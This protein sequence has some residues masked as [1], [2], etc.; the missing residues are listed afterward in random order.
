MEELNGVLD[1][2]QESALGYELPNPGLRNF[3]R[4]EIERVY[5]VDDEINANLLELVKMIMRCNKEDKDIP[6]EERK[7]IRVF[8][9]SPGGDITALWSTIK[10]IEISKT[11]VWT[12]NYCGCHSAAADLLA[13]GHK[14]F[15]LPGTT[16]MVHNGSC[17][18][19]GQVDVVESTKKYYDKLG[20]KII[21]YFL[22][23]T[24]IEPKVFK[25]KA[26]FDWYF[27]EQ[28]M[29]EHGLIDVIVS[30]FEEIM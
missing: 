18:F 23:H 19:Q 27:D 21:D 30:D 9:D 28:D 26:S 4:D 16:A 24:K 11:P 2:V 20:K 14:R 10:A 7:P 25:K 6:V 12:V 15:A 3:Y 22:E 29:L 8:I 1:C 17:G 13:A 5:W